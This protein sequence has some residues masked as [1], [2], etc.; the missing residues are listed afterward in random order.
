MFGKYKSF[1][2][3]LYK[4]RGFLSN[5][6]TLEYILDHFCRYEEVLIYTDRDAARHEAESFLCDDD[7]CG[8]SE[9]EIE[10][11][12]DYREPYI[13]ILNLDVHSYHCPIDF[14]LPDKIVDSIKVIDKENKIPLRKY[15]WKTFSEFYP[16]EW[17]H[18]ES[19]RE[20]NKK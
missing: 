15:L 18:F 1:Y 11:I 14:R 5:S 9:I 16:R 6:D 4:E 13:T 8:V 2:V 7:C 20:V 12:H 10:V 3:P 19:L 17:A